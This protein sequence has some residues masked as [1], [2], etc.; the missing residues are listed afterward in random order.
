MTLGVVLFLASYLGYTNYLGG[1][2]G[3]PPLPEGYW[4]KEDAGPPPQG[5]RPTPVL[6]RKLEEAFGKDCP[7]AKW[8]IKIEVQARGLILVSKEF[9]IED[10][11]RVRLVPLSVVLYGKARGEDG[12]QET[13][14]I[15]GDE[16]YIQFEHP[17]QTMADM[18]KYRIVA[19]QIAGNI[20]LV[21]NRR[22]APRDDDLSVDIAHGP[23]Y[24]RQRDQ[25]VWTDDVVRLVDQQSK[26]QP[27]VITG[28]GMVLDLLAEPPAGRPGGAP[29]PTRG[30]ASPAGRG[31]HQQF[32]NISGVKRVALHSTVDMH[33]YVDAHS[34]FLNN[35]KSDAATKPAPPDKGKKAAT[36]PVPEKAQL[37]IMTPGPFYYDLQ[38]DFAQF[39][40]PAQRKGQF[41]EQVVVTRVNPTPPGA[42]SPPKLDHLICEHLELQFRKKEAE[43]PPPR[44]PGERPA[45]KPNA[46]ADRSGSL[47]VE[48]AH[49]TGRS[50]VL[51]SDGESLEAHGNDFSY[52]AR[53]LLSI[54]KGKPMWALKE[55]NEITARELQIHNTRENQAQGQTATALGPGRLTLLDKTKTRRSIEAQ[56]RDTLVSSKDGDFDVLHLTGDAAFVDEENNQDLRADDLKVWL[57]SKQPAAAASGA[58]RPPPA[59]SGAKS[60]DPQGRRPHHLIA[61]GRVRAKSKEFNIHDAEQ[62]VVWFEDA[63]PSAT[64]TPPAKGTTVTPARPAAPPG[65][66][67]PSATPSTAPGPVVQTPATTPSGAKPAPAPPAEPRKPVDL[68]ARFVEAKVMR[69][70]EQNQLK[71]LKA[72]GAV[73][74]T[75]EP[76]KAGQKGVDI[77]GESLQMLA[78]PD[79]NFLTVEGATS[80]DLADADLA[81]LEMDRM[82]ILGPVVNINQRTNEAWVNGMGAMTM[83][84][85]T[86]FQGNKLKRV[87]PLTIHWDRSM[88]FDGKFAEFQGSIQAVQ[89]N[90]RL[91]CQQLQVFFDRPISLKE[92]EKDGQRARVKNL[93]CDKSVRVE[94]S[95]FEKNVLVKFQRIIAGAVSYDNEEERMWAVADSTHPGSVRL[96]QHEDPSQPSPARS[97]RPATSSG[98]A[99]SGKKAGGKEEDERKLTYVSFRK[100]MYANK[101]TN[102][103]TFR[104]GVRVLYQPLEAGEEPD[105]VEI[106]LDRLFAKPLRPG[107]IYLRCEQLEVRQRTREKAKPY[108]E[109]WALYG[110]TVQSLDF[111]GEAEKVFF[112][113]EK[114]LVIFDGGGGTATLYKPA[115]IKGLKGQK[116]EGKK[117]FY[118]RATGQYWGD[119]IKSIEQ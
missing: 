56:W 20:R 27:T 101:K 103:A 13:N 67:A 73:H 35:P 51:T 50:V 33:L 79:G 93:M 32:D 29:A 23:L 106:D 83:E 90:A 94:D 59:R 55:G 16:A 49:A 115:K 77:H 72:K 111:S 99:G 71:Q 12:T 11:G 116:I 80:S 15:R 22:T 118:Q 34:G 60:D 81:R 84:S 104:S 17:I 85:D 19:G 53:T 61:N 25:R 14:T 62:F 26:P 6:V 37:V 41:P 114:D 108:Q 75:Q 47:Q 45:T 28:E 46:P 42:D 65:S 117:I 91:A 105:R 18:G 54:L 57:E 87:V 2:D 9:K 43:A 44:L 98:P 113:E 110:V 4:P 97:P 100:Q 7:E 82:L 3:L 31:R 48:T 109:I 86:D 96:Y 95:T 21:N 89:E 76:A 74:V 10:D 102:V 58:K 30:V 5:R 63:P 112:D 88:Y 69:I 66:S 119:D 52:D 8:P 36:A 107:A 24:Y 70:G 38:K 39:D 40:I 1:V 68:R 92:G 78:Y 64:L